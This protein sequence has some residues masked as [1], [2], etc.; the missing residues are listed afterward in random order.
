VI[1]GHRPA[2][3]ETLTKALVAHKRKDVRAWQARMQQR[4][5]DIKVD[6]RFGPRSAKV[7]ARFAAEK[8]IRVKHGTVDRHMYDAAWSMPVT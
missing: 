2:F 1:V 7:A 5:W 6:G 4:G 3:T 8:G